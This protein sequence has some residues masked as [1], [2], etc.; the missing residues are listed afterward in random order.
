MDPVALW[1][2]KSQSTGVE[3][4]AFILVYLGQVVVHHTFRF[5]TLTLMNDQN[6]FYERDAQDPHPSEYV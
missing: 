5:W 4:D 6:T 3:T 1:W 2:I